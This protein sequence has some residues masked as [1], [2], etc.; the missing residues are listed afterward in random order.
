MNRQE[1]VETVDA[2]VIGM[3]VAGESVAGTLAEAGWRVVGIESGL[4]GGECPYWGCIPSKMMIRA[5]NALAEARRVDGLAG[6]A[7]VVPDW[8]PVATRIREQATD[9]WDDQ[10]AVDRFEAKGGIFVRGR[11][12]IDG[13]GLV[14]VDDRAFRA[15]RAI[16][17]ATGTAP[18]IPP[19][20]GGH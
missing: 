18:A 3:G 5:A 19:I 13:P 17:V 20:P 4:V 8:E 1:R 12:R 2:V 9:N 7:N 15:E 6:T 16:V 10:V 14:V 11:A